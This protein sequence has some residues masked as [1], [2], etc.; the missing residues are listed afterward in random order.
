MSAKIKPRRAFINCIGDSLRVNQY[1]FAI[2]LYEIDT[3][4]SSDAIPFFASSLM[5]TTLAIATVAIKKLR[6]IFV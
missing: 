2:T 1:I 4:L 6:N 3:V 5:D